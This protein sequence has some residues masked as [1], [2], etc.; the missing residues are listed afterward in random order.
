MRMI[1]VAQLGVARQNEIDF[2]F[3][4]V[5]DASATSVSIDGDFAETGDVLE[6]AILGITL[7][8]NGSVMACPRGPGYGRTTQ[9][10]HVAMQPCRIDLSIL[11]RQ[12]GEKE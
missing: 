12:I 11:S 8:K 1:T 5:R 6:T 3:A 9:T 4:L 10:G 7:A 2:F